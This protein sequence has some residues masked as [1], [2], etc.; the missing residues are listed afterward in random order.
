MIVQTNRER[1]RACLVGPKAFSEVG[2]EMR[3][4]LV[5]IEEYQVGD[6]VFD[7]YTTYT[8]C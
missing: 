1:E 7:D 8:F 2:S 5:A 6:L 3:A 4:N